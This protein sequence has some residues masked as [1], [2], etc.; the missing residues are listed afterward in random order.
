MMCAAA[1]SNLTVHG[2][3]RNSLV[4]L[5]K[6]AHISLFLCSADHWKTIVAVGDGSVM[7]SLISLMG[8]KSEKVYYRSW[9]GKY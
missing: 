5:C 8:S 3:S 4:Q 7:K 2:Q 9:D 1:L 6:R